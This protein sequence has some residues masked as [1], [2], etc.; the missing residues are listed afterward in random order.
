MIGSTLSDRAAASNEGTKVD[1]G[2][3]S[4][5]RVS[6]WTAAVA[7]TPL[8]TWATVSQR[9]ETIAFGPPARSPGFG[10]PFLPIAGLR[11][12]LFVV[13]MRGMSWLAP[14]VLYMP[15]TDDPSGKK[16][17]PPIDP[18]IEAVKKLNAGYCNSDY[19]VRSFGNIGPA[20]L[21]V[22]VFKGVGHKTWYQNYACRDPTARSSQTYKSKGLCCS[23]Q[24]D[25]SFLRSEALR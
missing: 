24:I 7:G 21:F 8:V 19:A 3:V 6:R 18:I 11:G 22:V 16:I 20:E 25:I 15:A 10:I 13:M 5:L 1:T 9:C 2:A 17:V 23:R 4:G 14:G 12:P